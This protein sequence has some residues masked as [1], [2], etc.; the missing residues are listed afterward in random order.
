MALCGSSRILRICGRMMTAAA[1]MLVLDTAYA[2]LQVAQARGRVTQPMDLTPQVIRRPTQPDRNGAPQP[3]AGADANAQPDADPP[4]PPHINFRELATP[5]Q[6]LSGSSLRGSRATVYS[7]GY[8]RRYRASLSG[9]RLARQIFKPNVLNRKE[10]GYFM[11]DPRGT[12]YLLAVTPDKLRRLSIKDEVRMLALQIRMRERR[13]K[14]LELRRDYQE[15]LR[16]HNEARLTRS[17]RTRR[18]PDFF[19]D[20]SLQAEDVVVTDSGLY[21]FRGTQEF[22]YSAKDFVPLAQWRKGRKGRQRANRR[23]DALQR[24]LRRS[25]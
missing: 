19:A 3:P 4:P 23:L 5:R 22:P 16:R 12:I 20:T 6:V 17:A 2:Q 9:T 15:R 13:K 24:E 21:V 25:R 11:V 10:A 1:C 18:L 8:A 7:L 14:A